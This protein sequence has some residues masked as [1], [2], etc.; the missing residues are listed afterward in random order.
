MMNFISRLEPIQLLFIC[1]VVLFLSSRMS[2]LSACN[3]CFQHG[4]QYNDTPARKLSQSFC[5]DI[6][7]G[8]A[9]TVK[10]VRLYL[11]HCNF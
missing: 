7:G 9:I 8:K 5:L 10:Q 3:V 11:S 6:V 4:K 2:L 1:H